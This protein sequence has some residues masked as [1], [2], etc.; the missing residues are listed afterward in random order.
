MCNTNN[1]KRKSAF[2]AAFI[3]IALCLNVVCF[4][5]QLVWVKV[6]CGL[7]ALF[8][9]MYFYVMAYHVGRQRGYVQNFREF[10]K[11]IVK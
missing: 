9:Y 7:V 2:I 1:W 4:T 10:V 8:L 11:S 6:A 5:E 3:S